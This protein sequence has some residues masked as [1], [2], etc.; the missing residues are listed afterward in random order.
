V[1]RL[2]KGNER[3]KRVIHSISAL[4]AT[5]LPAFYQRRIELCIAIPLSGDTAG[6]IVLGASLALLDSPWW[7][8]PAGLCDNETSRR[9][10]LRHMMLAKRW[11]VLLHG[12]TSRNRHG[13]RSV[14]TS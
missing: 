12:K 5:F 13:Q 2:K 6:D 1:K 3:E 11:A 10:T 4:P 8:E 7:Y 9:E 14:G